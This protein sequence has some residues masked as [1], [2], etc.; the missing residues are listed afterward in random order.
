MWYTDRLGDGD[1]CSQSTNQPTLPCLHCTSVRPINVYQIAC[2]HIII[3]LSPIH[4]PTESLPPTLQPPTLLPTYLPT[5][6]HVLTL[7][8]ASIP[9]IPPGA[10]VYLHYLQSTME[11]LHTPH[12]IIIM[13][14][15]YN[16]ILKQP[17][18]PLHVMAVSLL[19]L[20][21]SAH[22]DAR[23]DSILPTIVIHTPSTNTHKTTMKWK[24]KN[25][26]YIHPRSV[27]PQNV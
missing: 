27:L 20:L 4:T 18:V 21:A 9:S 10:H 2:Y 25:I 13:Y 1:E 26:Q 15:M 16:C 3:L 23:H 22:V 11:M 17:V 7:L 12:Y 24:N 5:H 19:N 8:P 14:I 6:H